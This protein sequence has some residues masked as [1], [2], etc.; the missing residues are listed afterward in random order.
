MKNIFDKIPPFFKT[1]YLISSFLLLIWLVFFDSN[2]LIS[3]IG[4]SRKLADLENEAEYFESKIEEVEKER[5][6]LLTD[7]EKLEKFARE[8]YL[9]KKPGEEVFVI[10]EDK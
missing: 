8:A 3:Q 1:F 10:E 9:M 4:M 7:K 2:D 5:A 6:A